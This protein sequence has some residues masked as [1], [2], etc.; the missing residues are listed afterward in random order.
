MTCIQHNAAH[1]ADRKSTHFHRAD[2]M[3]DA[4]QEAE[5][6]HLRKA[7]SLLTKI[8][9]QDKRNHKGWL[10]LSRIAV[11]FKV[12]E[13]SLNNALT[14]APADPEILEEVKKF[15][16]AKSR[17]HEEPFCRCPFC[18]VPL[19]S[20]AVTCPYCKCHLLIHDLFFEADHTGS[21]KVQ[22]EAYDRYTRV[23]DSENSSQSH[24]WLAMVYLNMDN[25]EEALNHLDLA[26]KLVPKARF[27]SQ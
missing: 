11:S 7:K 15:Q 18:W 19:E 3:Q 10:W 4:I 21:E 2:L 27:Y 6:Y 13:R 12:V 5:G 24:Y 8:L 20:D 14:I 17:L 1:H 16:E 25:Y 23:I 22:K 26:S 9:K